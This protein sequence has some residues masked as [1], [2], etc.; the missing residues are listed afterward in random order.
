MRYNKLYLTL[1][2]GKLSGANKFHK[3]MW[4]D[5]ILLLACSTTYRTAME[6]GIRYPKK[7]EYFNF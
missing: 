3:L 4:N 7:F 5:N 2:F 6:I 1:L